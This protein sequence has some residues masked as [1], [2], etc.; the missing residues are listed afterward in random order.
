MANEASSPEASPS[1]DFAAVGEPSKDKDKAQWDDTKLRAF[2][3]E[4]DHVRDLLAVVYDTS[5]VDP[6]DSGVSG[7][8]REQNAR[9]AEI[10]TVRISSVWSSFHEPCR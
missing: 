4:G 10:T 1:P 3:D 5:D 7:L 8:F 9:L 2:F 6:A